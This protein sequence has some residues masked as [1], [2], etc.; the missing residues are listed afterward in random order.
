MK[1]EYYL[2]FSD[3][4]LEMLYPQL[5]RFEKFKL[6]FRLGTR[7]ISMTLDLENEK[8]KVRKMK[9]LSKYILRRGDI[10][11][12]DN[13]RSYI[14][15]KANLKWGIIPMDAGDMVLFF[16]QKKGLIFV[17]GGTPKHL[18]TKN[19]QP[20]TT[21]Q[22]RSDLFDI[23]HFFNSLD[24]ET[25]LDI[26]KLKF[27]GEREVPDAINFISSNKNLVTQELEFLAKIFVETKY[28]LDEKTR[29]IIGSPIYV[30]VT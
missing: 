29:V 12:I 22:T 20:I 18:I 9:Q 13:P 26:E 28:N 4:K 10:G 3:T 17:L 6:K 11:T 19:E 30:S 5:S 25:E 8:H 23:M 7:D 15:D 24:Y 27:L 16:L 2:Y 21:K 1:I 14:K